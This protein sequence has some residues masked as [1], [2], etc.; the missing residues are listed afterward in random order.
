MIQKANPIVSQEKLCIRT[1]PSLCINNPSDLNPNIRS[2]FNLK[3]SPS[4]NN[5]AQSSQGHLQSTI[6]S[7][8]FS[9]FHLVLY[10]TPLIIML[11]QIPPHKDWWKEIN[12]SWLFQFHHSMASTV[13][14]SLPQWMPLWK[15]FETGSS[16]TIIPS[17]LPDSRSPECH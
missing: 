7:L 1:V 5:S 8:P 6:C 15:V 13:G 3:I 14:V 11:L 12:V 10:F 2:F 4:S 9:C 17:L 16:F